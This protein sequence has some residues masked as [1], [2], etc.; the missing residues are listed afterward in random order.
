MTRTVV[1]DR[2]IGTT[3]TR[4]GRRGEP[5]RES[6]VFE[7]SRPDR[8]ISA[9]GVRAGFDDP[10]AALEQLRSGS[11]SAVVGALPFR[12]DRPAALFEPVTMRHHDGSAAVTHA[13]ALPAFT[14]GNLHDASHLDRVA[15]GVAVLADASSP[16][17]KVVLAR[18]VELSSEHETH[19]MAAFAALVAG[20]PTGNGYCVDLSSAGAEYS[21]RTLVGSSPEVLI[22]KSGDVVS[23]HPLAGSAPRFTD[24][25]QDRS[26]GR[27]LTQSSKDLREHAFV[28]D[29]LRETLAPFCKTLDIPDQPTLTNTPQLWHLGTPISGVLADPSTP[30]LEM[31]LALHP[32]PA[33]CGTPTDVAYSTIEELEGER[34]FYGGAV[35]WCDAGGDGEWM[36]TIRCAEISAD[37]R[38]ITAYGGGGIIAESD[39]DAE[40]AETVTKLGTVLRALGVSTDV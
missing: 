9:S 38:R 33:V 22:R 6:G 34:G 3:T 27:T 30:S 23:C 26:S 21:G 4:S 12:R 5:T 39:P 29:A 15:A 1:V 31:A 19:P 24:P 7:L 32:T 11:V 20:T 25:E 35:G 14:V 36:V 10:R 37:R 18:T 17:Q 28:V 16:L 40:L 8:S 13:P 2:G